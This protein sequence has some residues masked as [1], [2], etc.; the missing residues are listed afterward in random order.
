[1]TIPVKN[2]GFTLIE[3]LVTISIIAILTAI[4]ILTYAAVLKQGR[5]S[6]RQA[7]LKA[8]QSALEQYRADS[9]GYPESITFGSTLV[10]NGKTYL[11]QV[12][13]DPL[14]GQSYCYQL[15][16][17]A[18]ELFANLENSAPGGGNCNSA[19]YNFKVTPP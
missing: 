15:T 9:I 12:P 16:G 14:S 2:S 17:S 4:G 1:M 10:N 8:I 13:N 7:D 19:T 5:D 11:N 3:L 6:K 18:Y